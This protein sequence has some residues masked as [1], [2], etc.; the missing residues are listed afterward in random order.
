[1]S[2]KTI[3]IHRSELHQ[4][5]PSHKRSGFQEIM[6]QASTPSMNHGP[7]PNEHQK[8]HPRCAE[9]SNLEATRTRQIAAPRQT[10]TPLG[11]SPQTGRHERRQPGRRT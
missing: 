1:M 7:V 9:S 5:C 8:R 10:E 11:L 3:A 6:P 4:Y 2:K